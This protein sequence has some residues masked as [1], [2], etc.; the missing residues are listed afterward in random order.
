ML[1]C[2]IFWSKVKEKKMNSKII[3]GG[4]FAKVVTVL[5]LVMLPPLPTAAL[6]GSKS[7]DSP[8]KTTVGK[9]SPLIELEILFLTKN[10]N[11]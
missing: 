11:K 8:P 1:Y 3:L 4:F 10:G 5:Y 6:Q 9:E 7:L 2:I